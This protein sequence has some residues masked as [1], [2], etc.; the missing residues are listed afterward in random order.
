[1]AEGDSEA[2]YTTYHLIEAV[3]DEAGAIDAARCRENADAIAKALAINPVGLGL[4]YMAQDCARASGD[5][6]LAQQRSDRFEALLRY[7]FLHYRAGQDT[8]MRIVSVLDVDAVVAAS[9]QTLL[10]SFYRPYTGGRELPYTVGLWDEK[11]QRESVLE[12]DFL[13]TVVSL[14]RAAAAEFPMFRRDFVRTLGENAQKSSPGSELALLYEFQKVQG[15]QA[16]DVLRRH[17]QS[18]GFMPAMML[19][20]FC[21]ENLE[22]GCRNEGIDALLPFAEKR[23]A[24][25]LATLAF[26]YA[27]HSQKPADLKAARALI[28][29]ADVRLGDAQGSA[30]F[31]SM[32]VKS[33]DRERLAGLVEKP[34][35]KAA[36]GGDPLAGALYAAARIVQL[37]KVPRGAERGYIEA[38][39]AAGIPRAQHWLAAI[40]LAEEKTEQALPWMH[41]AAQAGV[42]QAQNWLGLAYYGGESGLA[43]DRSVGLEWL[44]KA[45][46]GGIASA[47][48]IVGRHYLGESDELANLKRAQGWLQSAARGD[49]VSAAVQL[50]MLYERDIAGIGSPAHAAKVYEAV[51]ARH[52]NVDARRQ[53]ANLLL[54]GDGVKADVARAVT[55]LQQGAQAGD[56]E[57]QAA[58]GTHLLHAKDAA[59]RRVE[60]LD[61]VRKAAAAGN[62]EARLSLASALWHGRAGAPEHA[63]A[64]EIWQALI[65][66]DV[67][68][69]RNEFAWAVC[70][71]TDAGLLDAKAGIAATQ[72]QATGDKAFFVIVDTLAACQAA[73]GDYAAAAKTQERAIALVE[74]K[75]S[76][77][78]ATLEGMRA[79]L[80]RY[81]NGERAVEA[82]P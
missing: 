9:G 67:T 68:L 30:T 46:H 77:S 75:P 71:P 11:T 81:R 22:F 17:A 43:A 82:P 57:S 15:A 35:L 24:V 40:Y 76:A 7:T 65:S 10:Y 19:A 64:R 50:G 34:L 36:K 58:L 23:H 31:L 38:A 29:Q 62:R 13:D 6:I 59:D 3:H 61:W 41:A 73:A 1:M 56:A 2:I 39:A 45:G 70:T 21:G 25:A 12:F 55:L 69:A 51:I 53:L 66:E 52:D 79:R 72:E 37:D 63:A 16:L 60:G 26:V 78:A 28:E 42:A 33:G 20:V 80:A 47:S 18:G 4:W 49:D 48:A 44:K 8:P 54:A 5:E 14:Q 27:R 74:T 32:G